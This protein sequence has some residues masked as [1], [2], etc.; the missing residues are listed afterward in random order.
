MSLIL[1]IETSC[2][3]TAASVVEDG[4]MVRSNII[5]TQHKLHE[6]YGGVVPELASRAHLERI[7]PVIAESLEKAG[8]SFA[9]LDAIADWGA[10]AVV[11][12]TEAHELQVLG[13]PQPEL[14]AWRPRGAAYRAGTRLVYTG[15]LFA[16]LD[17]TD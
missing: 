9:D 7:S 5:A 13:V 14:E 11:T 10:V 4:V 16:R 12:L 3:E 6:R 8:V 15:P 2:D 17:G 1:G